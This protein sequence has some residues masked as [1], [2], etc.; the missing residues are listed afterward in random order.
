MKIIA[1]YYPWFVSIFVIFIM[2]LFS[3]NTLTTKPR[4]WYDEGLNI[5]VA[6]NISYF[7]KIEAQVAP[8][9]FSGQTVRMFQATGYP[10]TIPLAIFFKIFGFGATQARI[11][12]LGWMVLTLLAVFWIM[13]RLF[14]VDEAILALLLMVTFPPF[15]DNA[16]TVIGEI[17]GF[18]FLFTGCYFLLRRRAFLIGGLLIG[19]AVAAK[20]SVYVALIPALFCFFLIMERKRF[21]QGLIPIYAGMALPMVLEIFFVMAKP[22]STSGWRGTLTLFENPFGTNVSPFTYIINNIINIPHTTTLIYFFLLT[23]AIGI[24]IVKGSQ[25]F[26]RDRFFT[27]LLVFAGLYG[28]FAFLYYL[29]SPGWLRYL[30]ATELLILILLPAVVKQFVEEKGYRRQW[31]YCAIIPLVLLQGFHLLTRA[32]IFYSKDEQDVVNLVREELQGKSIGIFNIPQIGA[33]IPRDQK[34]QTLKMVGV[35]PIGKNL[36]LYDPPLDVLVIRDG[37]TNNIEPNERKKLGEYHI[38]TIIGRYYV[39]SRNANNEKR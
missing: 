37:E 31:V 18:F 22:F 13:R 1:Q 27:R 4:L 34:Y 25:M 2:I 39:Y 33:F 24:M 32:N 29:K 21:F 15:H 9:V 14:G 7:H 5:E 36:L 38:Y 20:I 11:Y 16:R 3:L 17:P 8:N 28:F 19:L 23:A 30:V 12:M 10:V 26:S 35:P 6:R